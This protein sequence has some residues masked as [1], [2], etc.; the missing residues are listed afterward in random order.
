MNEIGYVLE[1]YRMKRK[2]KNPKTC[3]IGIITCFIRRSFSSDE[4]EEERQK[5]K[6]V[7]HID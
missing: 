2:R 1:G 3:G 7:K 6:I 5:R 4:E